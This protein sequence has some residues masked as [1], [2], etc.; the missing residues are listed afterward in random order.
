MVRIS[1]DEMLIEMLHA[2]AKRSSCLR[3]QVGAL[4][5]RDGRVISIGY[6]GAPA[7]KPHCTPSTCNEESPCTA[8]LHA[9]A[10][11]IAYAARNGI[12][13]LDSW[14]Y[15]TYSPCLSCAKL[16]LSS[17]ITLLAFESLYRDEEPLAF[18][19]YDI[20]YADRVTI[21]RLTDD[22]TRVNFYAS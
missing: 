17:G 3:L 21:Q 13:L 8:T 10:N 11:A 19:H 15:C 6:N 12:A 9:E 5:V 2:V 18:L 20:S 7:G 1:R 14:L 16:I 4:I 22:G